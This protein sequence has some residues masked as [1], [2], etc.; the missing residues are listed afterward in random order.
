MKSII[1]LDNFK[2]PLK[3]KNITK[4]SIK[5]YFSENKELIVHK[6]KNYPMSKINQFIIENK[7]KIIL[8]FNQKL[9]GKNQNSFHYLGFLYD[10]KEIYDEKV[11]NCDIEEKEEKLIVRINKKV[12]ERILKD[13]ILNK[14]REFLYDKLF[15]IIQFYI[16]KHN[17]KL[18]L[19]INKIKIKNL[20]S[21]WGSCSTKRNLNFNVKLICFSENVIEYV[22]VHEMCHLI[23]MNHSKDFWKQVEKILP[24]YKERKNKLNNKI[25]I[26]ELLK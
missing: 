17:E 14:K 26:P 9:Q 3:I 22:V 7:E 6:P 20:K 25:K 18:G 10:F 11:L 4:K 12:P 21:R 13:K 16:E 5:L 15:N 8:E 2:I 23:H 19:R 1:Y 24:D